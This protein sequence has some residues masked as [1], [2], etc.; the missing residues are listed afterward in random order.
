[1]KRY[2][3]VIFFALLIIPTSAFAYDLS[4]SEFEMLPPHCQAKY[5]EMYQL[6]KVPN[7]SINP[8]KY[9]PK[10]WQRRAGSAWVHMHHYCPALKD[11][12]NA[13]INA[14][15]RGTLLPLAIG[16]LEYQISHTKWTPSNYWLLAEAHM[17]LAEADEL[18]NR[19]G[20]AI[21]Q[22]N[23]AIKVY[24]KNY[25]IYL[26]LS[27]L[28]AKSGNRDEALKVVRE[29]LKQVP[30]SKTLKRQEKRLMK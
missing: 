7:I 19:F 14:G 17:K 22:Y 26:G 2:F 29:G 16:N 11:L 28:L 21:K 24:P 27:R 3:S 15:K 10:L 25:R 13:K 4:Q 12:N 6:G 1:M 23:E 20:E 18:G 30:K 5:A 8:N 9:H